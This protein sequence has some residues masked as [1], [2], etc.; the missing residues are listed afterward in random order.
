MRRDLFRSLQR[1]HD[2]NTISHVLSDL[3]RA[4]LLEKVWDT[5]DL[6]YR[7]VYSKEEVT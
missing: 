6:L 2:E 1:E 5:G 3:S 7:V 4:G